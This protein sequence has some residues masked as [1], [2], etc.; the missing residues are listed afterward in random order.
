MNSETQTP[1]ELIIYDKNFKLRLL[2]SLITGAVF[3]NFFLKAYHAEAWNNGYTAFYFKPLFLLTFIA[4]VTTIAIRQFF[5]FRRLKGHPIAILN[6]QGL[7][8]ENFHPIEWSNIARIEKII[9]RPKISLFSLP[10]K[11]E[12]SS[13]AIRFKHPHLVTGKSWSANK[14]LEWAIYN[15]A[16]HHIILVNHG[17][18]YQEIAEFAKQFIERAYMQ[19]TEEQKLIN[20]RFFKNLKEIKSEHSAVV[21]R[22]F[23]GLLSIYQETPEITQWKVKGNE[24]LKKWQQESKKK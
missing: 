9:I 23:V 20:E 13:L 18:D 10:I 12:I 11:R 5:M 4:L 21:V 22:T 19:M 24:L 8:L 14:M 6:E 17:V 3:I 15:N 16:F 7:W 2:V 1:Q